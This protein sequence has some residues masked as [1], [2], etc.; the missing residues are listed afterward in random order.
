MEA[1]CVF[2]QL[3]LQ[4]RV[5]GS[6]KALRDRQGSIS[7]SAFSGTML[8]V[9]AIQSWHGELSVHNLVLEVLSV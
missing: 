2:I 3:L 4:I 6:S 1:D 7:H 5:W 9:L 8:Q